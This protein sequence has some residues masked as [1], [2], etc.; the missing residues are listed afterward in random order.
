MERKAGTALGVLVL[1]LFVVT[2]LMA[3]FFTQQTRATTP[4]ITT[5][6]AVTST[7]AVTTT[8]APTP[9][10]TGLCSIR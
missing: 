9:C 3:A 7:Q 2:L 8:E 1:T 6:T 5:T 4:V 10:L